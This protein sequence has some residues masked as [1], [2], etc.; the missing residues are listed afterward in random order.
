M[1]VQMGSQSCP[2]YSDGIDERV[3]MVV[4]LNGTIGYA[5]YIIDIELSSKDGGL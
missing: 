3:S 5:T 1:V 4:I 2:S